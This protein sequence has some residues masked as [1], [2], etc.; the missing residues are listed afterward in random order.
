MIFKRH[1]YPVIAAND[2]TKAFAL[3]ALQ[4][5]SIDGVITDIAMPGADGMKRWSARAGE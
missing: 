2:G 3:F 5:H 4:M 1:N